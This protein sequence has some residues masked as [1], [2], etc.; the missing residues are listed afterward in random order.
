MTGASTAARIAAVFALLATGGCSRTLVFAEREGVNIAIRADAAQTPPLEVNFGYNRVVGTTV[1]PMAEE[2]QGPETR[3][4]GQALNMVS[5]FRVLSAKLD[6]SMPVNVDVTISSQFAAGGAA[7]EI[8]ANPPVAAAIAGFSPDLVNP[9]PPDRQ[10]KV[11]AAS[12][13]LAKLPAP[14][15]R[16]AAAILGIPAGMSDAQVSTAMTNLLDQART[17]RD[18]AALDRFVAALTL[19]RSR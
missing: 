4:R 5:G 3:P 11:R 7:W 9:T 6:P 13:A 14:E 1:P 19:A 2:G 17:D 10:Q 16:R 15:K 8:A 18:P 12:T